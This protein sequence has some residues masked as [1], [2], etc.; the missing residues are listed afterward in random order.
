MLY[1]P[2][3]ALGLWGDAGDCVMVLCIKSLL[4]LSH[5]HGCIM[6]NSAVGILFQVWCQGLHPLGAGMTTLQ[7]CACW[8]C[9]YLSDLCSGCC[10]DR[11]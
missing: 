4:G 7:G 5:A 9:G 3:V 6:L 1:V 2:V 11:K 10:H 8:V